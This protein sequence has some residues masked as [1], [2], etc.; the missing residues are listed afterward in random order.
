MKGER[1]QAGLWK[2]PE[3]SAQYGE[4]RIKNREGALQNQG[5]TR[6]ISI[7]QTFEFPGKGS[8]RKAIANQNIEIAELGLEQ[9][10]RVLQGRVKSLA[11]EYGVNSANAE[12]ADEIAER[13]G[14]LIKL[15]HE[16]P[17]AG[18]PQ[19]LELRAIEGSLIELKKSAKEFIQARDEA[20]ANLHLL[21][22]LPSNQPLKIEVPLEAPHLPLSDSTSL[23]LTALSHNT[24]LL[25]RT[26]E[27]E[28]A[29][30]EVTSARWEVAPDFK[31]G[32]FFSQD[33]AGDVE[34]NFGATLSVTLP[35]WDW[36][37]GNI[38]SAQARRTQA[39]SL[40]LE[41]RRQVEGEVLRRKRSYDLHQKLLQ[42]ISS[43]SIQQLRDA[44]DLADRQYR[45][46]GIG[47]QLFLEMQRQYL[48]SMKI[49]GETL[50]EVW[51]NWLDLD[52]LTGG[53]LSA[54]SSKETK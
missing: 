38:A 25:I 18:T 48:S 12:S 39:D 43:S 21:L 33:R 3:V 28:K 40:L 20:S 8:L 35:L 2:N 23:I 10:K 24:S 14:G 41:A 4:R 50:S 29:V 16:R 37:Q 9:F 15:L 31:V 5:F 36:N 7:T 27:L 11:I 26:R 13:S 49:Q 1:T 22:G 42:E 46:G 32:P 52:L 45:T 17:Y 51:K 30:K 54:S 53:E 47:I 44:S 34:Q 19:L 6:E